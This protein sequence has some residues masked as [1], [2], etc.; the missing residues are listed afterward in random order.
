MFKFCAKQQKYKIGKISIGGFPG[1]TPTVLVGTIFYSGQK[2][3]RN[4]DNVDFDVKDSK[5]IAAYDLE[6]YLPYRGD[7][8]N[9]EWLEIAGCFVHQLKFIN[10]FKIKEMKKREIWTGC[11]GLGVTRWVAAFLSTYGFDVETWPKRVKDKFEVNYK[12]VK[13][14]NWPPKIDESLHA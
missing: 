5:N 7:R 11:T 12:P 1:E 4:E 9:S 2:I 10:S 14:L 13:T 3:F 8:E 6:I